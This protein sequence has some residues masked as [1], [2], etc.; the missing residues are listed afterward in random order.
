MSYIDFGLT[1]AGLW[2]TTL[3]G[4]VALIIAFI[5]AF[6]RLGARSE[7]STESAETKT[8]VSEEKKEQLS[9]EEETTLVMLAAVQAYIS[10]ER[11]E[12]A[13]A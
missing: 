1:L 2:F 9:E 8:Q 7:E 13:E 5:E 10:E 12:A 11:K 3:A 6:K 4:A